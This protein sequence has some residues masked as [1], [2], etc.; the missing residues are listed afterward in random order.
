KKGA[1]EHPC[2]GKFWRILSSGCYRGSPASSL[3]LM[4][5]AYA[6]HWVG[7]Y[8]N[9]VDHFLVPSQFAKKLLVQR[10]FSAEKITVLPHFQAL[11]E[12]TPPSADGPILYFGRLSPEKGVSD[13]IRAMSTLPQIRLQIAGD[14]SQRE[15]LERLARTLK[16]R[17]IAF[18]G[19]VENEQLNQIIA[20]ACFTVLPS[21]AYE[22]LG[23]SI[24]ESY[25]WSRAVIASDLGSRREL[26][27]EHETGLLFQAGNVEQ[28][29][30][31]ISYLVQRPE[32]AAEMGAA[33][34]RLLATHHS[35][36]KHYEELIGLYD[37]LTMPVVRYAVTRPPIRVAFIGGRGVISKYSGIETYYEEVGQ[38]LAEIGYEVS[39]YCRTYFTPDMTRYHGMRLVRLPTIRSKH[40]ETVIHTL[41][42][43]IHAMFSRCDIVHY[44]ALG[45]ALF[46]FFPRLTGKRTVVTV[47]GLDWQRKKWGKLATLT[48]KIGEAASA[49]WPNITM[50][51]SRE[52]QRRY[53]ARY[54]I[55]TRCIPNG[56][57]IRERSCASKILE[58]GLTPDNYILFL[59]RF[60]PEKNCHLLI[61]AYENIAT[62]LKL[63]LAG[64]SSHT[65]AYENE[66]R[67]HASGRVIFLEW[68]SGEHLTEL[69]TNAAL[70]V[71]PSDLEGL[72][73]ALLDAMGAGVCVLTSDIAENR[74]VIEDAGFT[75]RAGDVDDLARMLSLLASDAEIR[76]IAGRM[77]KRIVEERYQWPGIASEISGIY[78]ELMGRSIS[79]GRVSP[80]PRPKQVRH[81]S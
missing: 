11:P 12:P 34:R 77:A 72:S 37:R 30:G 71:L 25:A 42:S 19:H 63:V 26:V 41:I 5:E 56:A 74:E 45:S 51:V 8:R 70:F 55:E 76:A 32:L 81:V 61:D 31:A 21:R 17:N 52:L 29:A 62:S 75:F 27:R 38:R 59:G 16:L 22:T 33:G 53:K 48:L 3:V 50:V 39:V 28:L 1:C 43:T 23:K 64:G 6:H 49:W 66:L 79:S 24:L 57:V 60:S 40:L 9:C 2:T 46:S 54:R 4:S 13:L 14:G 36:R 47:Q 78:Q 7:T 18:L 73:L 69:L 58:W 10:G 20:S 80:D 35:P 67:K 44:H 15:E 68:V 65:N